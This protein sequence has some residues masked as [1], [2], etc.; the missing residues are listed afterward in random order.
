ML[1]YH[2]EDENTKP[3]KKIKDVEKYLKHSWREMQ[4][5]KEEYQKWYKKMMKKVAK[6]PTKKAK[7][8]F[9]L[10]PPV[11]TANLI[12]RQAKSEEGENVEW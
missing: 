8:A 2:I 10:N 1:Q 6:L 5:K 3:Q 11:P 9:M 4:E 12:Y 7:L